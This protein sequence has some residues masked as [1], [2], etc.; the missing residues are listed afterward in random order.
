MKDVLNSILNRLNNKGTILS[1]VALIVSLLVQF[2]VEIESDKVIAIVETICSILLVLGL[3][4]NPVDNKDLYVPGVKD[5]LVEK[6]VE[7]PTSLP[8]DDVKAN[9]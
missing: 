3:M 2:G 7:E 4:N 8:T 1:L 9:Q 5:Q 6:K